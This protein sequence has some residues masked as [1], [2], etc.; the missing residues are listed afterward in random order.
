M[1]IF[2]EM[3]TKHFSRHILV[4]VLRLE[5]DNRPDIMRLPC[6]LLRKAGALCKCAADCG[7]PACMCCQKNRELNH[8]FGFQGACRHA[9]QD[10]AV[11]FRRGGKLYNTGW[12]DARLHLSCQSGHCIM[13]LVHNEQGTVEMEQVR[14][15]EF[16][17]SVLVKLKPLW[18]SGK[19]P[20]VVFQ[21]LMVVV[22]LA[23]LCVVDAKRLDCSHN[24]AG[25][26]AYVGGPDARKVGNVKD[27]DPPLKA[28]VQHT[29]VWMTGIF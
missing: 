11:R 28:V 18:Q 24:N 19:P 1:L 26:S 6:G 14:K 23:P 25:P 2:N 10:I 12:V 29:P 15:G 22:N 17:S 20:K 3:L 4:F 5:K 16:R 13:R 21:L 9:E 8:V 7:L 27:A